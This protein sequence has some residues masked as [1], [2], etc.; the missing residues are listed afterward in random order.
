MFHA[1][2]LIKTSGERQW[3]NVKNNHVP[4][5]FSR[6]SLWRNGYMGELIARS[7]LPGARYYD[8]TLSH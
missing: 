1:W 6:F 4:R 7:R 8:V 3:R 2:K 5:P